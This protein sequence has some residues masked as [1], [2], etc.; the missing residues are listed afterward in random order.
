ML[1]KDLY[2]IFLPEFIDNHKSIDGW[3]NTS[4]D[5]EISSSIKVDIGA[6]ENL[7]ESKIDE[8]ALKTVN[9]GH[10]SYEDCEEAC[11]AIP[12]CKQFSYRKDTCRLG[13]VFGAGHLSTEEIDQE[14]RSMWI[15]DRIIPPEAVA[16]IGEC[17]KRT[18]R[19]L[20]SKQFPI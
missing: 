5:I 7:G 12:K 1:H 8:K 6:I 19:E 2:Q 15:H 17:E 9:N 16:S 14:L 3:N 10:Q 20:F 18:D 13:M 11:M 4:S